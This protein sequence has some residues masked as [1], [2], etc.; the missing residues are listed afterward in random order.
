MP[1]PSQRVILHPRG[2]RYQGDRPSPYRKIKGKCI[3]CVSGRGTSTPQPGHPIECAGELLGEFLRAVRAGSIEELALGKSQKQG[4]NQC[5]SILPT[6]EIV[7]QP[8][9]ERQGAPGG[10]GGKSLGESRS[11]G[12]AQECLGCRHGGICRDTTH[13]RPTEPVS[14]STPKL[15]PGRCR[16]GLP[17][18]HSQ[19][20][21]ICQDACWQL[22]LQGR[23]KGTCFLKS[24]SQEESSSL[25]GDG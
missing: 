6:Q 13:V 19:G 25:D 2:I 16:E 24:W 10:K 1:F 9:I 18:P 17:H 21:A 7:F 20:T 8:G 14:T 15:C 5:L 23:G 22:R 11:P 3:C 12:C 4:L